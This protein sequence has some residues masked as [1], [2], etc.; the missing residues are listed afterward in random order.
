MDYDVIKSM[1]RALD[2]LTEENAD[3]RSE[4][5]LLQEINGEL[6]MDLNIERNRKKIEEAFQ[7]YEKT[8]EE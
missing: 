7:Q 6:R 2:R 1:A 8:K 3:L 5:K 4:V